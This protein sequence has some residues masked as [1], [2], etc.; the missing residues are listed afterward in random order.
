MNEYVG[1][2]FLCIIIIIFSLSIQHVSK[3]TYYNHH[4]LHSYCVDSENLE[5]SKP[6]L[7]IFVPHT[8]NSRNWKDFYSRNTNDLNQPY[9]YITIKSII[10]HCSSS[11]NILLINQESFTTLL[12]TW[13]IK[14]N[15][16]SDP[17]KDHFIQLGMHKVLYEYGGMTIPCSFLC[18]RD[19]IQLYYTGIETY[20]IFAIENINSSVSASKSPFIPDSTMMGCIK[21]HPLMNQLIQYETNLYNKDLSSQSDFNG[22]I[23]LWITKKHLEY[24]LILIDSTYIGV[25]RC[26]KSPVLLGELLSTN[27]DLNLLPTLYGILIPYKHLLLQLNYQWFIRMSTEQ[28]LQS[29]LSIVKYI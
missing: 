18:K 10:D 11:F 23:N 16:L 24:K 22:D 5:P 19:L 4:L 29:D 6:I 1:L 15:F 8:I 13:N 28:I 27:K 21:H 14:F 25:K 9:L 26:N 12:P 17:I 20:D 3:P 7:W 2:L